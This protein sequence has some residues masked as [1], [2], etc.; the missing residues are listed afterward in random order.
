MFD[1]RFDLNNG[2]TLKIRGEFSVK[3]FDDFQDFVHLVVRL[4]KEGICEDGGVDW[5]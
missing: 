3:D 4:H 1:T 5:V 2:L